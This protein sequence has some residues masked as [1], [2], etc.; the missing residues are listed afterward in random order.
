V[1][2][3]LLL[4]AVWSQFEHGD[5]LYLRCNRQL[6]DEQVWRLNL[7]LMNGLECFKF[8]CHIPTSHADH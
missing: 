7:T 8:K 1:K 5:R 3:P 4:V 2:V 6:H